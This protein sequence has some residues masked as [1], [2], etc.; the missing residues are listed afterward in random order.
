MW[1]LIISSITLVAIILLI[2][3]SSYAKKPEI[4]KLNCPQQV[5]LC[6]RCRVPR[7]HCNCPPKNCEF[8]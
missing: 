2:I 5:D 3:Y 6:N 8:C 7:I 4:T 1:L